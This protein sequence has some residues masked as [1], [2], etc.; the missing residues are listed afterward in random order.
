M[1]S[2]ETWHYVLMYAPLS[3]VLRAVTRLPFAPSPA[4]GRASEGSGHYKMHLYMFWIN[5]F[6]KKIL[7]PI[8]GT[9]R[10]SEHTNALISSDYR[11]CAILQYHS[12]NVRHWAQPYVSSILLP[13]FCFFIYGLFN[14]T[15]SSDCTVSCRIW[16]SHSGGYLL[17]YNA[18]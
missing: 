13:S 18:V 5:T 3:A 8:I 16:S 12:T 2:R 11:G 15:S 17:A 4:C 7:N 1:N 14:T 10:F 9:I 6:V